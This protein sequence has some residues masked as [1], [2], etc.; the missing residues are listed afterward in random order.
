MKTIFKISSTNYLLKY[1][2]KMSEGEVNKMKSFVTVKGQ[3]L[4][5]TKNFKII[6]IEDKKD[7][8]VYTITL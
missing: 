6:N 2:R 1:T 7:Q 8:R 4:E 5:K 3:K